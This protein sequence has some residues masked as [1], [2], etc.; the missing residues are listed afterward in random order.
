[1]K[2]ISLALI[3]GVDIP[4]EECRLVLHQPKLREIAL[5]GEQNFLSGSQC[6][7]INK[8]LY[9]NKDESLLQKTTNFQIFMTAMLDKRMQNKKA[10]VEQVLQLLLPNYKATFI[11]QSL[12]FTKEGQQPIMI[13]NNNFDIFQGI[14]ASIFCIKPGMG[15]SFNPSG[16]KSQEIAE[17][18]MR[19]RQKVAQ[20]KGE[21]NVS[22]FSTYISSVAIAQQQTITEISEYTIYQ[23]YDILERYQ[24]WLA[25]D[26]DMKSR[27]AGGKPDN[28]PENWMKNIH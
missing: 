21:E 12:I 16:K 22:S 11:P 2:D 4:I 28:K 19:A 15:D 20:E 3:T 26:I 8:N 18:L 9:E 5:I 25:W 1:M 24:L 27:L 6:L 10:N 7:N 13:D 17:K 23:L 14:I